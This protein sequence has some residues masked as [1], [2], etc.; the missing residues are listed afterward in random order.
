MKIQTLILGNTLQA[1][2]DQKQILGYRIWRQGTS[3][4]HVPEILKIN[5]NFLEWLIN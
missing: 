4:E 5:S 3:D 1:L 2:C